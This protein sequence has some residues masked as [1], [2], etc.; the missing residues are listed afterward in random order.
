MLVEMSRQPGEVSMLVV[1]SLPPAW[2]K[3]HSTC[4]RITTLTYGDAFVLA[5]L[6]SFVKSFSVDCS[7]L[8]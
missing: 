1:I 6:R 3:L 5:G 2:L 4:R 8:M 7:H